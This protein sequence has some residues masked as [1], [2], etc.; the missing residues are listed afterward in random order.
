M[1]FLKSL[2]VVTIATSWLLPATAV[3]GQSGVKRTP[4]VTVHPK[5]PHPKKSSKRR[6]TGYGFLPGYRQ[7][8]DLTDW[9]ARSA[10]HR[11]TYTRYG[12]QRYVRYS[13]PY[14]T[15]QLQYGWGAPGFYRGRWNGGSF[16]PC[17][18]YTPICMMWNCGK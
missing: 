12:E 2:I 3:A 7:P 9:R 11:G 10:R 17:W 8:P 16:G 6:W 4:K 5:K 13:Y 15:G 1:P 18:T 14:G